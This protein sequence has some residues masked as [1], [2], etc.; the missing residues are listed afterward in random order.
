MV[1]IIIFISFH[2]KLKGVIGSMKD[3]AFYEKPW[4][5]CLSES[6]AFP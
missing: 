4:N 5:D 6:V 2:W 3:V 1:T